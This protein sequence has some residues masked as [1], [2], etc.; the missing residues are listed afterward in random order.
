LLLHT[1]H[2]Q[3]NDIMSHAPR[4]AFTTQ[5]TVLIERRRLPQRLAAALTALSM[6][7]SSV[8]LTAAHAATTSGATSS[9]PA[10]SGS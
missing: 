6:L 4:T 8:G 7:F 5:F 3:G 9:P 2:T 1:L 10:Q